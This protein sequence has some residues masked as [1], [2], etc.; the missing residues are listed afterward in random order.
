M[1]RINPSDFKLA[2]QGTSREINRQIVLTLIR[3]HQPVSR[4]DL[5]RLMDTNRANITFLVNELLEENWIREGA[6]G[7]EKAG[8]SLLTAR[9]TLLG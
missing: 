5:S 2:K 9:N 3:T 1:R 6:R 7:S 4:A 8:D